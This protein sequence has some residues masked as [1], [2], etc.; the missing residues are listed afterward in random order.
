MSFSMGILQWLVPGPFQGYPS[1]WLEVPS[2]GGSAGHP[3]DRN[4]VHPP[5][6]DWGDPQTVYAW[7]GYTAGGM[8]LWF[9]VGG[10]SCLIYFRLLLLKRIFIC[11]KLQKCLYFKFLNVHTYTNF[12]HIAMTA[13]GPRSQ[14]CWKF[15]K[16]KYRLHPKDEGR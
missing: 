5:H 12:G 7:T 16:C 4:G 14:T 15:F 13:P 8:L 11:A 6:L 3:Q 2:Q 9:P 1:D 10:L